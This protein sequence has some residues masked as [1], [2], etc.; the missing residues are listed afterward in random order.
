LNNKRKFNCPTSQFKKHFSKQDTLLSN[1]THLLNE[2][3]TLAYQ[4]LNCTMADYDKNI[5][6][7]QVFYQVA[8]QF[9]DRI[10]LSYE[11]GKMTYRQLNQKSNQVA[12]MLMANGLQKGDY[13]AI[14]MDRSKETIIS[15]LGVL[16]AGGVYVQKNVANISYMILAH[17]LS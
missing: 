5:T 6:I 10:A 14:I 13:V 16:K 8:Q 1:H 7:P 11:D 15:L 9:A 12:H 17:H 3:D 2:E 4:T